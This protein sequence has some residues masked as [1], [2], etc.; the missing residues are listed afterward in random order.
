MRI[1][2][3]YSLIRIIKIHK[4]QLAYCWAKPCCSGER[5]RIINEYALDEYALLCEYALFHA[6]LAYDSF[7]MVIEMFGFFG[8]W[9]E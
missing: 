4:V 7:S 9:T 5:I 6:F 2:N 8:L 1:N 3:A